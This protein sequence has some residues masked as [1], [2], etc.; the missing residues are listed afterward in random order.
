MMRSLSAVLSLLLLALTA[1]AFA[2]HQVVRVRS[3][4][5]GGAPRVAVVLP[6]HAQ[7]ATSSAADQILRLAPARGEV[8]VIELSPADGAFHRTPLDWTA[9]EIEPT[10]WAVVFHP[11]AIDQDGTDKR[12]PPMLATTHEVLARAVTASALLATFPDG[13]LSLEVEPVGDDRLFGATVGELHVTF[14]AQV[15]QS[16]RFRWARLMTFELLSALESAPPRE[17]LA[18]AMPGSSDALA[19][20]DCEGVGGAGPR[21]LERIVNEVP[22]GMTVTP[23][24]PEDIREGV[25]P[26]FRGVLFPGGGGRSIALALGPEGQEEVRRFVDAGGGYVGICAGAYLATCRIDEYLKMVGAFHGQPWRKGG[27]MVQVELTP[28]GRAIFGEE[29]AAFETRYNNGPVLVHEEGLAPEGDFPAINV[30]A[31]FRSA[32]SRPDGTESVEMIDQ[33]AVVASEYGEGR[34]LL[35]SPHPETHER[36]FPMVARGIQWS[37]GDES[38]AV[39]PAGESMP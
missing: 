20:Y 15:P 22:F 34:V 5:P 32:T 27:G 30:L 31:H 8:V 12:T 18:A 9:L 11:V 7:A 3:A 38:R 14:A 16:R 28:E 39:P 17:A 4:G 24:S 29:F 2:Q 25:L 26:L 1:P 23:V 35:I 37:V 6:H 33:A 36:L 13:E 10:D 21:Q 19:L